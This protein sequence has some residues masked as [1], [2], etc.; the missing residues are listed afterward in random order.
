[1]KENFSTFSIREGSA[2]E[3]AVLHA[4][5]GAGRHGTVFRG[6]LG[7]DDQPVAIKVATAGETLA[8]EAT[9][10]QT[11]AHPHVVRIVASE[12]PS[13][14]AVEL[15]EHGTLADSTLDGPISVSHLRELFSG[16]TSA[17]EHI[18]ALGWIH[19]DVSPNN[20]G[21]RAP[22]DPAL[23]DFSTARIADGSEIQQGTEAYAGELRLAVPTLDVRCAAVVAKELLDGPR[24][25]DGL[26]QSEDIERDVLREALVALIA[27][28]DAGHD[29]S[30]SDLQHVLEN[31]SLEIHAPELATRQ[32]T[33][34][35]LTPVNFPSPTA[36]TPDDA[37]RAARSKVTSLLAGAPPRSPS[38]TRDFGPRPG[39]GEPDTS[40]E[41][42]KQR[43][44]LPLALLALCVGI[45]ALTIFTGLGSSPDQDLAGASTDAAFIVERV[46]T[47]D[48]TLSRH[49][50]S[51]N[52]ET[53]T[54][55]T[56]TSQEA[57][58]FWHVGEPGDIAAIGDWNC[59][60]SPT[61]GVFRPTTGNWFTFSD[62]NPNASSSV[63]ILDHDTAATGLDVTVRASG[64]A[65]P[66]VRS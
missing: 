57:P 17:L 52:V 51:W 48:S 64:C 53:G 31:P 23:I 43:T 19:G 45:A 44:P 33:T 56:N 11:L 42:Q 30:V 18:H 27:K 7:D 63:E 60:G 8:G 29:V 2:F 21:M 49:G 13:Q 34:V 14:I 59:D 36:P 28:A 24:Q 65:T 10:L 61:L 26:G 41:E 5:L 25:S 54:L 4:V 32:A 66:L 46:T 12:P 1:M 3:G 9:A 15:C 58:K 50:A 16:L 6:R 37:E 62:W 38:Q 55:S 47:A 20:I 39:G 22:T 35:D 40:A